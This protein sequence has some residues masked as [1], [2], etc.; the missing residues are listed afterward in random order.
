[1]KK[2]LIALAALSTIAGSV[3]AQS[4]VTI[5]G[6]FDQSY[7][8][9]D[10]KT[11]TT[12]TATNTGF[13]GGVGGSRLG[14]RGT[15]DLGG[16]LKANFVFEFGVDPGENSGVASTR[17]G[18]A[19]VSGGFGT[20]RMGRQVSPTKAL[21]DSYNALGNNTNFAPGDVNLAITAND[22]RVSNAITYLTPTFNGFSAQV[23]FADDNTQT[24]TE[25]STVL[26]N[27]PAGANG[28]STGPW[29][30]TTQGK[31]KG[32]GVNYVAG[33]LS[34]GA[35]MLNNTTYTAGVP[36][37]Q[38]RIA[39]AARYNFGPLIGVIEQS[40]YKIHNS[41]VVAADRAVTTV[42]VIVPVNAKLS[43]AAQYFDGD[44]ALGTGTGADTSEADY[45]G[46]KVRATYALSKRTG[47][48]AQTGETETKPANGTQMTTVEGYGLGMYHNF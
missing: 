45:S 39:L 11:A 40:E 1:M 16:G 31:V 47:V 9:V 2:S 38:E 27:G 18:F 21:S 35:A 44:R 24:T 36:Q 43:L 14:F 32:A 19:D 34:I 13:D 20:F 12:S 23:Q 30:T 5:Y 41:D 22:A 7:N 48:Y 8:K 3:A 29:R 46:Y 6:R 26:A 4:S 42:G 37:S 33:Q 15:E 17:L 25:S 10:T 28:A